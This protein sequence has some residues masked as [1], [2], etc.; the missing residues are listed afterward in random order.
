MKGE[1]CDKLF[2]KEIVRKNHALIR[3]GRVYC[4]FTATVTAF[5]KRDD[6]DK[7][8]KYYVDL[9]IG[10]KAV[11]LLSFDGYPP[12]VGKDFELWLDKL[13]SIELW[14]EIGATFVGY[15]CT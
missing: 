6:Y 8:S 10:Q 9:A 2:D 15:L 5:P 14:K 7:W 1:E 12:A 11:L 13:M 4:E 3:E